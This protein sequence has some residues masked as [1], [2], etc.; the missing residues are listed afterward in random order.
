MIASFKTTLS[1]RVCTHEASR[2]K[3]DREMLKQDKD[4][5]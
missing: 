2:V 5:K 4:K 1:V 3:E